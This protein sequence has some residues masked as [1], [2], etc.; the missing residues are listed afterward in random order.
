MGKWGTGRRSKEFLTTS[1]FFRLN[2]FNIFS[3]TYLSKGHKL[4]RY[5]LTYLVKLWDLTFGEVY[6]FVQLLICSRWCCRFVLFISWG[7]FNVLLKVIFLKF[8]VI[9]DPESLV[10]LS[11]N[12]ISLITFDL[13]SPEKNT[14]YYFHYKRLSLIVSFKFEVFLTLKIKWGSMTHYQTDLKVFDA[15]EL[16]MLLTSKKGTT[17]KLMKKSQ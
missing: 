11:T 10:S 16:N 5:Q 1:Q 2:T 9:T 17:L 13:F 14:S 8:R 6:L 12:N 3:W 15:V 7:S 4:N